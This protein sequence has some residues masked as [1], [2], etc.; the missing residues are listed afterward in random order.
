MLIIILNFISFLFYS[1]QQRSRYEHFLDI[2]I[3]IFWMQEMINYSIT[4]LYFKNDFFHWKFTVSLYV[5]YMQWWWWWFSFKIK[6]NT[7]RHSWWNMKKLYLKVNSKGS[8][9]KGRFLEK[10]NRKQMFQLYLHKYNLYSMSRNI[11][12]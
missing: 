1:S 6:I 9:L 3:G 12:S 8:N 7:C 10:I 4:K 2:L 5:L 11:I